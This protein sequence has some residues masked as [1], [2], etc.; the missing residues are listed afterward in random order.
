MSTPTVTTQR[1]TL[2]TPI[3]RGETEIASIEIRKPNAGALRGISLRSLLDFDPDAI[4]RTLPRISTPPLTDHE[5]ANLDPA[6]LLQTG[7][8]IAGFLVPRRA[9]EEAQQAAS[10]PLQ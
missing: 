8:V 4:I 9:L 1:V 2:E 7:A 5:A 10:Y 3:K 6:D